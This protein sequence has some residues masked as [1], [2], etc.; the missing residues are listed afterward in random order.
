MP[1][2]YQ[3]GSTLPTS[4]NLTTLLAQTIANSKPNDLVII[5]QALA[6]KGV[7]PFDAVG[8]QVTITNTLP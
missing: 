2:T 4:A 1:M 5:M 6:A 3:A 7:N 8:A